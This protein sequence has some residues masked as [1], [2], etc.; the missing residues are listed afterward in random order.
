MMTSGGGG[1]S[2]KLAQD[3]SDFLIYLEMAHTYAS[4]QD[5]EAAKVYA[6][7]AYEL[8]EHDTTVLRRNHMGTSIDVCKSP[9]C[10]LTSPSCVLPTFSFAHCT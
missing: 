5:L 3:T 10:I 6:L 8:R 4:F 2:S 1:G 7:K 9:S